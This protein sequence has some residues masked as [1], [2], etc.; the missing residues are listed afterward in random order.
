MSFTTPGSRSQ[1]KRSSG[2]SLSPSGVTPGTYGDG[3]HV[4]QVTVDINGI[5]TAAANVAIS[6]PGSGTVTQVDTDD[7]YTTGGPVTTTGTIDLTDLAKSAI[8][9]ALHQLCGGI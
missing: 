5:V 7:T 1:R 3:T 9:S 4:S 2:G 8:N 6:V